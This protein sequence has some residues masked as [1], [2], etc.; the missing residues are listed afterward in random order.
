MPAISKGHKEVEYE[1]VEKS[2]KK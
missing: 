2:R 1:Y